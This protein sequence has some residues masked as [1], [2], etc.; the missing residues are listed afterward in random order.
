MSHNF[1]KLVSNEKVIYRDLLRKKPVYDV[2]NESDYRIPT[3]IK[4]TKS[5]STNLTIFSIFISSLQ[6]AQWCNRRQ[7]LEKL[8]L[9]NNDQLNQLFNLTLTLTLTEMERRRQ[10]MENEKL[11]MLADLLIK[12]LQKWEFYNLIT[13]DHVTN[14]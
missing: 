4:S 11:I 8:K 3:S 9:H 7:L 10:Y 2:I 5:Q 6:T 12:V 14:L 13:N 1:E